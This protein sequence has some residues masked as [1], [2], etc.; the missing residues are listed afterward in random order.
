MGT[1]AGP[2]LGRTDA[3][4]LSSLTPSSALGHSGPPGGNSTLAGDREP[5]EATGDNL[6]TRALPQSP[7]PGLPG[8]GRMRREMPR[9]R[10]SALPAP[11]A[12]PAAPR[13]LQ[14]PPHPREAPGGV[15]LAPLLPLSGRG[16]S[17][18]PG[19]AAP[20]SPGGGGRAAGP[21]RLP[22]ALTSATRLLVGLSRGSAARGGHARRGGGGGGGAG[23][24][25][26]CGESCRV[27]RSAR[28]RRRRRRAPRP[29]A[30]G[31]V[32]LHIPAPSPGH[33]ASRSPK[34]Q[35]APP[36]R[37]GPTRPARSPLPC[38]RCLR[39]RPHAGLPPTVTARARLS[40][41]THEPWL[42]RAAG[43]IPEEPLGGGRVRHPHPRRLRCRSWAMPGSRSVLVTSLSVPLPAHQETPPDFPQGSQSL[44]IRRE[45]KMPPQTLC[46]CSSPSP[47]HPSIFKPWDLKSESREAT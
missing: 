47:E 36:G 37:L 27:C 16:P 3:P 9:R 15:A 28:R 24:A 4:T 42:L 40:P 41:R 19:S 1:S 46:A 39:G 44:K 12:P 18:H 33:P 21:A 30:S 23:E 10:D 8:H 17:H 20:P 2:A 38:S 14:I 11:S 25:R 22:G 29:P 43:R 7:G 5:P 32:C 31:C 34:P 45:V 6:R 13:P 35:A 26:G